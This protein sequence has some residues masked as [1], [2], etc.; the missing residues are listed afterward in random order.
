MVERVKALENIRLEGAASAS[1]RDPP[2][3]ANKKG[4]LRRGPLRKQLAGGIPSQFGG[5]YM[6]GQAGGVDLRL[7][8]IRN[9]L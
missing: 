2:K 3:T 6:V 7:N 9:G 5:R 8:D 1:P 4:I